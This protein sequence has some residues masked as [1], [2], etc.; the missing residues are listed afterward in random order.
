[1]RTANVAIWHVNPTSL[2]QAECITTLKTWLSH[3]E[4]ERMMRF[5]HVKHQHA[6]LV[7]HALKRA[8]LAQILNLHPCSL[9]F[10]IGSH[11]RPH[12][13]G[14]AQQR[15]QFNLSHT[16]GMV[17]MAVSQDAY[18]GFDIESLLRKAPEPD[19][20][21]RFF[22]SPE[23]QDILSRPT[24]QQNQRL[25][26]FWTLKEAYIKAEGLGISLGLD[27]FYFQLDQAIPNI[28]YLPGA[29]APS[30][31]WQFLQTKIEPNHLTALAWAPNLNTNCTDEVSDDTNNFSNFSNEAWAVNCVVKSAQTLLEN[32]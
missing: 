22:T 31:P 9:E 32:Y 7:S 12:L 25:L 14:L 19:F 21:S 5:H 28:H 27:T 4:T 26:E 24:H 13:L 1:M 29:K 18:V 20:A 3:V 30:H 2:T 11:G 8:V 6:F 10:G 23:H 16:D 15:L 17:A